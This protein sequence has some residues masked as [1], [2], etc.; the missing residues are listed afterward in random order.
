LLLTIASS[1]PKILTPEKYKNYEEDIKYNLQNIHFLI[2]QGLVDVSP[3][4]SP[5]SISDP[6]QDE[7][8]VFFALQEYFDIVA[9]IGNSD[10]AY[11]EKNIGKMKKWLTE[12]PETVARVEAI[13]LS[14]KDLSN[15]YIP[16]VNSDKM[17]KDGTEPVI[18]F[19]LEKLPEPADNVSGNK[20]WNS[21]MTLTHKQ[22]ITH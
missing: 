21:E 15:E 8:E 19:I 6:I 17:F 18:K 11:T 1:I 4:P 2:K 22:N 5:Y 12:Y 9:E 7:T 10:D 3:Y 16:L 20:F 13:S 14:K